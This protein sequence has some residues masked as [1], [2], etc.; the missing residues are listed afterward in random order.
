MPSSLKTQKLSTFLCTSTFRTMAEFHNLTGVGCFGCY[1]MLLT[2][3]V[4]LAATVCYLL[5]VL[6]WLLL[7]ATLCCLAPK[8][9]YT[10][11]CRLSGMVFLARIL[12][13]LGGLLTVTL[14]FNPA[15]QLLARKRRTPGCMAITALC[16]VT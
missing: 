13:Q 1:C 6:F 16:V 9:M 4:V 2:S 3:C 12:C 7:Y 14:F 15:E 8:N 10:S 11:H 5:L